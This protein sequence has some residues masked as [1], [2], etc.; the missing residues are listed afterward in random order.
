MLLKMRDPFTNCDNEVELDIEPADLA[1]YRSGSI[2]I[3]D[4][5]P[6]LTNDEREFIMTGIMPESW[7]Q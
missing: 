1:E 4:A 6:H 3:Q 7:T 5:F 2:M